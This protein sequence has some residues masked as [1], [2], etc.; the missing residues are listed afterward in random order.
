[1]KLSLDT[2]I[3][4][5]TIRVKKIESVIDNINDLI[6]SNQ[7]TRHILNELEIQKGEYDFASKILMALKKLKEFEPQKV[8]DFIKED[9]IEK[10]FING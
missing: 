10:G 1:M 9:L 5:Q 8:H 4:F 2:L 3:E 6:N 7:T